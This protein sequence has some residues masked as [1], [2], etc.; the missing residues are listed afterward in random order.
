MTKFGEFPWVLLHC[1][2]KK[3]QKTAAK[4]KETRRRHLNEVEVETC[5]QLKGFAGC[6]G[7]TYAA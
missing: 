1:F 7:V 4:D 2:I 5:L 3:S 6:E